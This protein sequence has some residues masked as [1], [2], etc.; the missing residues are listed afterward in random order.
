MMRLRRLA[1]RARTLIFCALA[2][3]AS[4]ASDCPEALRGGWQGLLPIRDLFEVEISLVVSADGNAS[5]TIRTADG[6]QPAIAWKRA[7]EEAWV[8]LQA[9]R[10]A[11]AFN[12]R[13]SPDKHSID[14]FIDNGS[15]VPR[16]LKRHFSWPEI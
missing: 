7:G 12:G 5:A 15:R 6:P 13:V 14:G 1:T 8:Y 2:S 10:P 11:L 4:F 3:P 16:L 9:N